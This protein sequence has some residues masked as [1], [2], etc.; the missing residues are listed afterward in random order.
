M[1]RCVSKQS[2][3]II[4]WYGAIRVLHPAGCGRKPRAQQGEELD[5][6]Y[7]QA[8]SEE[9]ASTTKVHSNGKGAQGAGKRGQEAPGIEVAFGTLGRGVSEGLSGFV[10]VVDWQGAC[11]GS[12]LRR[13]RA[14]GTIE[15]R[16]V[17]MM[18]G[19]P[20]AVKGSAGFEGHQ[21]TLWMRRSVKWGVTVW[22]RVWVLGWSSEDGT[23][24]RGQM[25]ARCVLEEWAGV[26]RMLASL[27]GAM[28]EG[29][30]RGSTSQEGVVCNP[31]QWSVSANDPMHRC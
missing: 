24:R 2:S 28:E 30:G 31:R 8:M 3:E 13:G 17:V 25:G 14:A 20:V 1:S 4:W 27:Q 29:Q 21:A 11:Q 12:V 6:G 15:V 9:K 18:R 10:C 22:D 7:S 5:R 23:D 26:H 19:T 16:E